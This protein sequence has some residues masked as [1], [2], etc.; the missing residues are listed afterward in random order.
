MIELHKADGRAGPQLSQPWLEWNPRR[1]HSSLHRNNTPALFHPTDHPGAEWLPGIVMGNWLITNNEKHPNKFLSYLVL[2]SDQM[3]DDVGSWSAS[4][5]IAEPLLAHIAQNN[6]T[7]V[8]DPTILASMGW[9][10]LAVI[11]TF[12]FLLKLQVIQVLDSRSYVWIHQVPIGLFLKKRGIGKLGFVQ[13][14]TFQLDNGNTWCFP[15]G[16]WRL[17]WSICDAWVW[18]GRVKSRKSKSVPCVSAPS[19]SFSSLSMKL[20]LWELGP[21]A[22]TLILKAYAKDANEWRTTL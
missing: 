1:K 11:A 16:L 13:V 19:R 21:K 4:F 9:K 18:L 20:K 14:V 12:F 8:M 17:P 6:T 15:L 2:G 22:S 5:P 10:V 3:V 7:W